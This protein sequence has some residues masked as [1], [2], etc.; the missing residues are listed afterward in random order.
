MGSKTEVMPQKH[1]SSETDAHDSPSDS[2]LLDLSDAAI[3][4]LVHRAK[5]RGYVTYEQISLLSK[6]FPSRSK[7]FSRSSAK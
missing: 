5:K 6:S 1:E 2:P 4:K 3:K 7:T